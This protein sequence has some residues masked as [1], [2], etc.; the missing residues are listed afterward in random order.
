MERPA[1]PVAGPGESVK[2]WNVI[3][4]LAKKNNWRIG[5][6][7]GVYRGDTYFYLLQNVPDLTL[8]GV[9][10]WEVDPHYGNVEKL[11]A[12]VRAAAAR[13]YKDRSIILHGKSTDPAIL[14]RVENDSLDFVFIDADHSH[15][16]VL[17]DI[18]A[19]QPKLKNGGTMM[20]H[21]IDFPTVEGAVREFYGEYEILPDDV[22]RIIQK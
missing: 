22:W 18:N 21:D 15:E 20:G 2:R 1:T 3:A 14:A 17:A 13:K 5:A 19:W 9:D 6:E 7:I 4:E 8:I 16:A 12:K 11:G 10:N